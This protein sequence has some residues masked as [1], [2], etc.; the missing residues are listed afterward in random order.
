MGTLQQG[1]MQCIAARKKKQASTLLNYTQG[2][3]YNLTQT[4]LAG[5]AL[6]IQTAQPVTSEP[7]AT[8]P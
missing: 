3:Q 5:S 6:T 4:A 8:K 7:L 1:Q 2:N